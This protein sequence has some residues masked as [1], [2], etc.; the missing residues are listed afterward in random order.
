MTKTVLPLLALFLSVGATASWQD[1]PAKDF[2][3]A[4]PPAAGTPEAAADYD[5]LLKLQAA[6]KPDQC[7]I[8][9]GQL[10]PDFSTLFG[11]SGLLSK[12]ETA[13]VKPF[14]DSALKLLNKISTVFKKSY[15]RPRPYDVDARVKPCI[16]KP[17]GATSYPSTHAAAGVFDAC[18]LGRLF[19]ARADKLAAQGQLVG[20]LRAIAGVHHPSDVAA[21]QLLGKQLCARLLTETDFAAELD[22]VK[23][24]LP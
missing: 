10:A 24:S 19:P 5:S 20:D 4:P 12:D 16:D 13:A 23:Q 22:Q 9:G 11:A 15:G 1:V 8:A 17:G 7:A 6:R 3:M 14:L 2:T 21:G 18:V